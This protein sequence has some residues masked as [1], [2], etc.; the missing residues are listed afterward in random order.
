MGAVVV[1]V[2]EGWGR[3]TQRGCLRSA[4]VVEEEGRERDVVRGLRACGTQVLID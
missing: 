1:V 2:E 4:G 3:P